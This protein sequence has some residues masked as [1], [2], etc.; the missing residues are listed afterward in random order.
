LGFATE[1]PHQQV[2]TVAIQL[3]LIGV[4]L[5]IAMWAAHVA[6]FRGPGLV[7]W[8]GLVVVVQNVISSQFNSHL[9]DFTHGW[10]YVFGVGVIGGMVR[11][12]PEARADAAADARA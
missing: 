2:L 1:N 8:I 5:L 12:A 10:L 3:G 4:G 6:L 11:G 9:F 7:A